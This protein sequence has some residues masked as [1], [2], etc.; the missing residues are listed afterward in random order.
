[1]FFFKM[2]SVWSRDR[3]LGHNLC[4]IP[5]KNNFHKR[6]DWQSIHK[7]QEPRKVHRVNALH[8]NT[9]LSRGSE[10]QVQ[11][12]H[13]WVMPEAWYQVWC[14][15]L[16]LMT[17]DPPALW[18]WKTQNLSWV[19]NLLTP[20]PRWEVS[21]IASLE[22]IVLSDNSNTRQPWLLT[23]GFDVSCCCDSVGNLGQSLQTTHNGLLPKGDSDTTLPCWTPKTSIRTVDPKYCQCRSQIL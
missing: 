7:T 15:G 4:S 2:S 8:S 23:G 18:F 22:T 14:P 9:D 13:R 17:S 5:G 20:C 3:P 10:F 6:G 12:F 21:E 16:T 19:L 11:I 1:M